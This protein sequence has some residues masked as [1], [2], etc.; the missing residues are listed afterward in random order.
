MVIAFIWFGDEIVWLFK[1][2]MELIRWLV[3]L[4]NAETGLSIAEE[5]IIKG[6][7]SAI[8]FSIVRVIFCILDWFNNGVMGFVYVVLS[9]V[10]GFFFCAVINWF[11]NY[12]FVI[13]LVLL[14]ILI[15]FTLLFLFIKRKE[16]VKESVVTNS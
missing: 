12:W 1:K 6:I 13:L 16:R 7:A 11:I 2:L 14:S 3:L 15:G 8:S 5:W 9:I 10:L 4:D